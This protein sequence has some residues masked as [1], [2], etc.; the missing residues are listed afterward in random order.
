MTIKQNIQNPNSININ[1]TNKAGSNST[2]KE[3][4]SDVDGNAIDHNQDLDTNARNYV[5][6]DSARSSSSHTFHRNTS[7]DNS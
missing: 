1:T 4:I 3:V 2:N 6:G 7:E 5:S